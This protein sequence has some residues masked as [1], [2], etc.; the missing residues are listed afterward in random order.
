MPQPTSA[1]AASRAGVPRASADSSFTTLSHGA[2]EREFNTHYF[3]TGGI[4]PWSC[5]KLRL[6]SS[7]PITSR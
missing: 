2:G 1:N 4:D 7:A 5:E 3:R 6:I